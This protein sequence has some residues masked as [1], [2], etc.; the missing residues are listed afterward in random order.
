MR[1]PDIPGFFSLFTCCNRI[2]CNRGT[3]PNCLC[4]QLMSLKE[5]TMGLLQNLLV[6]RPKPDLTANCHVTCRLPWY[7]PEEI[8]WHW[9]LRLCRLDELMSELT[10]HTH[11]YFSFTR[12]KVAVVMSRAAGKPLFH[13]S[14]SPA[15]SRTEHDWCVCSA[16]EELP[17]HTLGS[18]C[19]VIISP[20]KDTAPQPVWRPHR[21]TLA[22]SERPL[23]PTPKKT[24]R[25]RNLYLRTLSIAFRCSYS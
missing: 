6:E 5:G 16:A 25:K 11:F 20:C 15:L 1:Q 3:V 17:L 22:F 12:H 18:D 10:P 23:L 21:T 13:C 8:N 7:Q 24:E 14:L 19:C 4:S 2:P 9:S